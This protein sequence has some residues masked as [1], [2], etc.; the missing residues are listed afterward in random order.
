MVAES[1]FGFVNE[2]N[3]IEFLV[4]VFF[5]MARPR[6]LT[7]KSGA[8]RKFEYDLPK[9]LGV[10]TKTRVKKYT[11]GT[12]WKISV[13]TPWKEYE[14][15]GVRKYLLWCWPLERNAKAWWKK[16][17]GKIYHSGVGSD[18]IPNEFSIRPANPTTPAKPT[19][20]KHYT[21]HHLRGVTSNM[22]MD[23]PDMPVEQGF[24]PTDDDKRKGY[25]ST[26]PC[27]KAPERHEYELPAKPQHRWPCALNTK[28][29][30]IDSGHIPT[31]D[32]HRER[33]QRLGRRSHISQWPKRPRKERH[34][35]YRL[36]A[37]QDA[38]EKISRRK[39]GNAEM[40]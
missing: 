27:E 10:T 8:R 38:C 5:T 12:A 28:R 2:V 20:S 15:R 33:W 7:V 25:W 24:D 23:R 26:I 11:A 19:R 3:S 34:S 16:I 9:R 22:F 14:V 40:Q 21:I 37:L 18:S 39:C 29:P 1:N 32:E 13:G 4:V 30:P 6:K 17:R 35:R 36:D 31:A